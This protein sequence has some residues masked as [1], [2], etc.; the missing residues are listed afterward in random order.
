M[1]DDIVAHDI[2]QG[3]SVPIPTTQNCL[4]PP[5]ARIASRL[6]AHPTGLALLISEQTFQE[7]PCIRRH[8]LLREQRTYPFLDLS[9]RR[10]PQRK[11]LLNRR[12]LRPRPPNH[13]CPWIQTFPKIATVMLGACPNS[14]CSILS[15]SDSTLGYEQ[16]F[17]PLE[18]RSDA[19]A[20]GE[21]AGLRAERP[22]LAVYRLTGAGEPRSQEDQ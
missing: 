8:A 10:R 5:W 1:L 20:A 14:R 12:C 3:I 2:A 18:Y 19:A 17:S 11:R 4:L 7:Q 22:C 13:G 21:C 6:R 16:V 9:K 15:E